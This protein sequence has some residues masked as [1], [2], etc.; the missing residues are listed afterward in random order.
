MVKQPC[1]SWSEMV[2]CV[3]IYIALNQGKDTVVL[4]KKWGGGGLDMLPFLA[5]DVA[6]R[7]EALQVIF[8]FGVALFTTIPKEVTLFFKIDANRS[9]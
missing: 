9:I 1:I 4:P 7:T 6:S 2:D 8:L 5:E 3:Y